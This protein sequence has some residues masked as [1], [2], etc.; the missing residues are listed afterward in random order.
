M[1]TTL[2]LSRLQGPT[3]APDSTCSFYMYVATLSG[4]DWLDALELGVFGTR[5]LRFLCPFYQL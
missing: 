2:S 3:G 5:V 4:V 1:A